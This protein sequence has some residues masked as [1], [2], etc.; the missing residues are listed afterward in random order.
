MR[1]RIFLF[2]LAAMILPIV[3]CP[4][5]SNTTSSSPAGGGSL[6]IN[7]PLIPA[8]SA[9]NPDP[10]VPSFYDV[11]GSGARERTFPPTG[12]QGH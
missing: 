5:P 12:Y 10:S 7:L 4:S 2:V 8:Q 11:A 1:K 6:T 3:G 9:K